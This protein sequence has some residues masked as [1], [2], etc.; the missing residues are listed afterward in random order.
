[1]SKM[2]ICLDIKRRF[3]GVA[4]RLLGHVLSCPKGQESAVVKPQ[5]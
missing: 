2:N 1:M 4:Y 5:D 3:I